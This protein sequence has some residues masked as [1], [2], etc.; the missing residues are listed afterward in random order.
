MTAVCLTCQRPIRCD[1]WL[2]GEWYHTERED[3][4]TEAG[5]QPVRLSNTANIT[6]TPHLRPSYPLVFTAGLFARSDSLR[7]APPVSGCR[8]VNVQ[9]N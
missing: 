7:L 5:L 2:L 6:G 4:T 9:L 1:G 3:Q 8:A